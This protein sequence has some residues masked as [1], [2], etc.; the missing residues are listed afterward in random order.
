MI[1]YVLYCNRNNDYLHIV[2]NRI[3]NDLKLILA[4]QDYK[5]NIR[6]YKKLTYGKK[7]ETGKFS[8]YIFLN[9]ENSKASYSNKN[10]D[11]FIKYG[12]YKYESN[13]NC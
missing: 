11:E 12:N 1:Y 6:A 8:S 13:I 10:P 2:Y 7:D 3:E 4:H 5:W 9:D